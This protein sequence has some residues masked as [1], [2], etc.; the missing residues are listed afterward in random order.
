M[1]DQL[2]ELTPEMRPIET[3][4]YLKRIDSGLIRYFERMAERYKAIKRL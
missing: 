1:D 3:A 4:N 2:Q